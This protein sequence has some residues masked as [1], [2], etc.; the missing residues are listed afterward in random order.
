MK[1]YEHLFLERKNWNFNGQVYNRDKPLEESNVE[2][3][4]Y[5]YELV[6]QVIDACLVEL[7]ML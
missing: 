3:D 4:F 5:N 1:D 7:N 2:Q 6:D